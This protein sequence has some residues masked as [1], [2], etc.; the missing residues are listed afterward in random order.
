MAARTSGG[1]GSSAEVRRRGGRR[2]ARGSR[3]PRST[4]RPRR[5]SWTS[6]SPRDAHVEQR[7][8]VVVAD[9]GDAL[10]ARPPQQQRQRQRA[11]VRRAEHGG[12][13]DARGPHPRDERPG[14]VLVDRHRLGLDP[15]RVELDD[16]RDAGQQVG[17][18]P[19]ARP[20]QQVRPVGRWR[21]PPA[22]PARPAARRRRCRAGRRARRP[23][24]PALAHGV[25]ARPRPTGCRIGPR[26]RGRP[27]RRS[28]AATQRSVGDLLGAGVT[29]VGTSTAAP[30]ARAAPTSAPMSPTT[31]QRSTGTPQAPRPRRGPCP[32]AG[33]RQAHPSSGP[34]GH[35]STASNGPSSSATRALTAST[36]AG[37]SRPR[38]TPL[39]FDTTAR[40]RPAARSRPSPAATPGSGSTRAGSPLYGT[41]TTSVPSRS[42]STASI[43]RL[44]STCGAYPGRR[45]ASGE[46]SPARDLRWM[47][48][49]RRG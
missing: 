11:L 8:G 27:R 46:P 45:A 48:P 5:T 24:R 4:S 14:V 40:R 30:A 15:R 31:A 25:R 33:L 37:V 35:H 47:R 23:R 3:A 20:A 34:C 16:R 1:S 6:G 9:G 41:S 39:W 7:A 49:G 17:R 32:G 38:A 10:D 42:H 22:P 18:R 28:R 36:C 21:P 12:V 44:S 19:A 26:A 13:G 43:A 29:G 2:R